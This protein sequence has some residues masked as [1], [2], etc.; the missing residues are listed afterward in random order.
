MGR[1]WKVL[2]I[3]C[4]ALATADAKPPALEAHDVGGVSVSTP[5]GWAFTG[6]ASKGMAIA[7]QDPKRKDA[8]Q[9]LVIV[10]QNAGAT[11]EDQILDNI[12]AQAM[13]G[14]KVIKRGPGPSN[15][16]KLLVADGN[17]DG[18]NVRLGAF[19]ASAGGAMLV[20]VLVAKT[21]E[22]DGLGGTDLVL[23]VIASLKAGGGAAAPAPPGAGAPAAP[24]AS[25]NDPVTQVMQPQIDSYGSQVIPP[26]GRPLTVADLAGEWSREDGAGTTYVDKSTGVYA[27][28]SSVSIRDIWKIDA[29]GN[30]TDDFTGVQSGGYSPGG[31]TQK[32]YTGKVTLDNR[33]VLVLNLSGTSRQSY[34]V[35]GW[36][37]GKDQVILRLAGP[38]WD[39]EPI[40]DAMLTATSYSKHD[41]KR[42]R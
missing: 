13:K 16:G 38:Y 37:Y 21:S 17:V 20:G 34:I 23:Q 11:T 7:Q 4:F 40:T 29:K 36:F 41:Y 32:R 5:K 27:G 14:I 15:T 33:G 24:A 26:P 18:I 42:K 19:A 9:L 1:F 12:A 39:N 2:V 31:S 6:D 28:H 35:K 30:I 10:S 8:A 22:F 3:T 25:G